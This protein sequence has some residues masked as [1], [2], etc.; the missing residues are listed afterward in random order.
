MIGCLI[1]LHG[2]ETG[3]LQHLVDVGE[4]LLLLGALGS[5]LRALR[6]CIVGGFRS[7]LVEARLDACENRRQLGI[8]LLGADFDRIDLSAEIGGLRVGK[9]TVRK[10]L[11]KLIERGA[12]LIDAMRGREL[13]SGRRCRSGL[14]QRREAEQAN[15]K[16]G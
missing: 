16:K 2:D 13:R 3:A 14:R 15:R 5:H 7:K 6:R 9:G 1:C 10:F 4:P 12:R 11:I 8:D